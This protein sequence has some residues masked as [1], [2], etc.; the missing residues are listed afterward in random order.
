MTNAMNSLTKDTQ[1][2]IATFSPWKNGKR[3]PINGN[4][5]PLID[6]FTSK[7]KKTVLIDQVYPGSDFVMPRIEAYQRKKLTVHRV[8]WWIY[9]L[10]PFLKLTNTGATHISFKIRDF[11]SVVDTG[12]KAESPFDFFIG[13]E[14][15]NALAGVLLRKFGKAKTV[16]Y[17]V[18]DY[19]PKRYKQKWF[20]NL[21]LWLDRQAAMHADIIWDVSWAMQ[22]ARI[23]A[24]LAADKSAPVLQVPNALY[25]NQISQAKEKDVIPYT[26]V[27]MGTLGRENGP[28]LAIECLPLV[29]KKIPKARLHIVGGGE[30]DEKRLEKLVKKLKLEKYVIFHG[31]ISDREKVSATIRQFAVALAPYLAIT[32]SA[33]L[34]GD[35]TKIRAYLAAGL[36]TI[37]TQVPP[38]GKDAEKK[39]AAIVVKDD[40]K[41]LADAIIKVFRD[42]ELYQSLRKKAYSF[43]KHNTWENEF[44]LGFEKMA[45]L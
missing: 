14:A 31:F 10:Y 23:K 4:V 44:S 11:L 6:F 17:Y 41:T 26:L 37:T 21:Y 38:L 20:N 13:L 33:R 34:Y 15:V 29:L 16:I 45:K 25:P 39:G 42:Q 22:P 40:K 1:V 18:S 24:G 7:V 19:S 8:S 27:F 2:L 30:A 35:A 28:D 32:G 12:V 5:E 43:A 9:V 3:L 36:P